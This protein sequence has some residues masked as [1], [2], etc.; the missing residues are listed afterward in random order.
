MVIAQE[1]HRSKGSKNVQQQIDHSRPGDESLRADRQKLTYPDKM[2]TALGRLLSTASNI[3]S[4]EICTGLGQYRQIQVS[5][6]TFAP[7]EYLSQHLENKFVELILHMAVI[8]GN[9]PRRP[10]DLFMA[11]QAYMAVLQNIDTCSRSF[12]I[13]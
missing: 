3:I 6:H 7:R 1:L 8:D 12:L 5:D 10:S 9:I 13:L 11:V 4:V 2:H